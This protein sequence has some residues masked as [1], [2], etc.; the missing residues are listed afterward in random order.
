MSLCSSKF[1]GLPHATTGRDI[2]VTPSSV[3]NPST[4]TAIIFAPALGKEKLE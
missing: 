1:N 2:Q 3:Y 4:D